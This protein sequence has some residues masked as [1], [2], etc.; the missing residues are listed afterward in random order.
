MVVANP[1]MPVGPG[2]R[3]LSP[4]SRLIR[5][6]CRGRL[7]AMMDCTLNLVD[8]R[9]VA[10]GLFMV[11]ER[12]QP[13]RRYLLGN[14]NLTLASVLALLGELT[15]VPVPRWNVPYPVGLAVAWLSELC[16]RPFHGTASEGHVDRRSPGQRIMHFDCLTEPRRTGAESALDPRITGRCGGWLRSTG[17]L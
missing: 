16:R 3:G 1:T 9:D 14:A 6:F 5:D 15:G 2:D 12:V 11:M 7:P 17:Q 10:Q 4:P 13:G 8:V